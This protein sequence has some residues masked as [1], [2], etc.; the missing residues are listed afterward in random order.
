V[1]RPDEGRGQ[2]ATY[3]LYA[4]GGDV[5]YLGETYHRGPY[6]RESF[7][8]EAFEASDDGACSRA[9]IGSASKRTSLKNTGYQMP[10][11][12]R[13][14]FPITDQIFTEKFFLV[15]KPPHESKES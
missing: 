7:V 6:E 14:I 10:S 1:A 12:F 9:G 5:G 2:R 3:G 8:A 15:K 4:V 11:H 13:A